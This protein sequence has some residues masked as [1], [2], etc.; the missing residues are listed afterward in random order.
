MVL[1]NHVVLV[2]NQPARL[3]F[4]DH[5]I[6][7]RTITDPNTGRPGI[8]NVLEFQCD[9]L[10]GRPVMSTFSTMAEKLASKFQPFLDKKAYRDYE[11]IIT[12]S[13]EGFLRNWSVQFIPLKK[14]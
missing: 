3:H 4:S 10:D 8:R 7:A 13:G 12:Q 1:Q 9:R 11:I 14:G 6:S 2:N 5:V